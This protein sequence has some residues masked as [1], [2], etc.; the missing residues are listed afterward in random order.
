MMPDQTRTRRGPIAYMAS[1]HVAANML[2]IVLLVGGLIT[3]FSLK[4]EVFPE[5]DMDMVRVTV[6]YPGA[7]P[8]EVE[9][10]VVRPIELAVSGIDNVKRVRSSAAESAGAV[11]LETIEGADAN[12]VLQDVKSEVDRIQTFPEEA[13]KPVIALMSNR[14]EV[15]LLA[16]YGTAGER[17]LTEQAERV[18]DDLLTRED[19]TMVEL[20]ANRPYEISI[21]IAERTLREYNLT[22]PS[23][24]QKVRRASL[25]LAGG[26]IRTD[27]GEILIRTTEKRLTGAEFDSVV[28]VSGPGGERVF[29]GDI[30]QVKDT[31]ADVELRSRFDGEQALLVR[32]Y[33][34]GDQKPTEI[35]E[36][37]RQ[38][39]A[40][41]NAQLPESVNIAVYDDTS[42]ILAS[43]IQLLVKNG[44]LGLFLVLVI[45]TL[46]L[47]IRLAFWVAAGIAITFLGSMLLLPW[48][49]VSINMI[50][51]F[52]FLIILGIVVDDA[53]VV[54]ENIYVHRRQGEKDHYIAAVNGTRQVTKAVV[55]AGLTTIAAFAPLLFVGG[56]M[57]KFMG[58]IPTIVISV[59]V[60]SLVES[61][62]ILPSHLN[63]RLVKSESPLWAKIEARRGKID[64][65]IQWFIEHTYVGTLNWARKNRY[66]TVAIA[67][68][69]LLMTIGL[70][71]GGYIRLTFMSE[72]DA[73]EVAVTL[74]M[75]PGTP[76]DETA[77]ISEQIRAVGMSTVEQ[78]DRDRAPGESN[79]RHT[80][81]LYGAQLA[82]GGP[83][84]NTM[85]T[86]SNLAQI[87][88]QLDGADV[89]TVRTPVFAEQWRKRVGEIPGVEK[90]N[91]RSDLVRATS[92]ME[93]QLSHDDFSM[94]LAAA[95]RLKQEIAAF[96][97][98]SEVSDSHV[99]GKR[100][101]R[102]KLRPEAHTLGITETDL[103]MQVRGAFYGAEAMRIQRGKNEVKVMVRYPERDR[104]TLAG[105][106]KMRIRTRSG[107]EIPFEQAAYV[108]QGRG[109]STINRTDRRRVVNVMAD[110]DKQA[111]SVDEI[112]AALQDR[113]LPRLMTEYP[114]LSYDL[115][116][117]S[118]DQ[119]EAMQDLIGAFL[120]GLML[121]YALLA[122]PFRS[123]LQPFIVMSAIPFGI[124]GAVLG[125]LALGYAM[126]M[127]SL[128]G[129]VALNGVVVNSS[130]VMIH[131]I[132]RR[133][134]AGDD[135]GD[136]VMA[137][138]KRRFRP[139]VMTATTT[140][141]GLM[142]IIIET[143]IQARFLIP[144][145]ISLGFGVLFATAITLVLV[146]AQYLILEDIRRLF[147]G[148]N[149]VDAELTKQRA[150]PVQA[151]S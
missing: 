135:V 104:R 34:V 83:E 20:A 111:T 140:F 7:T 106:E 31:F 133:R 108:E 62:F 46:F 95:D 17:A 105:I 141:F 21:E 88:F 5:F 120:V 99:E 47:E 58:V 67:T 61:F 11:I 102:L 132:N 1:N 42:E 27:A 92:D 144:M 8:S 63:G 72:V 125:H 110:V 43:R 33:R 82:S 48:F 24:A 2:M 124:V 71:A 12:Q 91:F 121:I 94:L 147:T 51:L 53:I 101:L 129:I 139:I 3:T 14:M 100:E 74:T 4:Q 89:R 25:D 26:K 37:V 10:A 32:V 6:V 103:A 29:L 142:P 78:F 54:G 77:R 115:E 60:L 85:I 151:A 98:T 117:R 44:L 69:L 137:A 150:T 73:D 15:M 38:Y 123:F 28:V 65:V 9:E 75:P 136:A 138:G 148:G 56:F 134:D 39:V 149:S 79:L 66:L 76:F 96:E 68:A 22:L 87:Y 35:A 90:L 45:L 55:F 64:R 70:L 52:A 128:F 40:A 114:G 18:R 23:V 81:T 30:A 116:G 16:V 130:L 127:I 145:A 107:R 19:I 13:E 143:S 93:I 118:R 109:F 122:I 49:D 119:R 146:P 97:G 112:M 50:S 131:F 126:S 84:G 36:T 80:F 113:V 86:G 57:G 59:L 41:R